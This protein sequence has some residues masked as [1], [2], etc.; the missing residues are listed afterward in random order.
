MEKNGELIAHVPVVAV[1]A[2][3]RAEQI[4]QALEA[5]MDEV[6][7]KPFRITE[8]VPVI[9]GVLVRFGGEKEGSREEK[10]KGQDKR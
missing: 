9:E 8:L 4:Q 5:G 10:G 6:M 2:N 1:T 7:T 3:A